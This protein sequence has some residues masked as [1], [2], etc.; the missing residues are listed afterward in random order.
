MNGELLQIFKKEKSKIGLSPTLEARERI[1]AQI[2]DFAK[3]NPGFQINDDQDFKNLCS[4][5]LQQDQELIVYLEFELN[6]L[7]GKY[8]SQ[9]LREL[10]RN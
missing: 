8:V 6:R 3:Q 7:K 10:S 4:K 9:H 2:E 5:V 1:S